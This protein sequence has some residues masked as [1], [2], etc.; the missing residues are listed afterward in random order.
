MGAGVSRREFGKTAG[1]AGL[2]ASGAVLLGA[3][4][5]DSVTASTAAAGKAWRVSGER[6]A[7]LGS[8][9]SKMKSF[10][11]ARGISCGQLA[12]ARKG[13]LVLARGYTWTN[14]DSL[15]TQPT[16]LFRIASLSK[17]VTGAAILRL[18]QEGKLS[19]DAPVTRLLSLTAPSGQTM[20]PRLKDVTVRRLLHHLGGWDSSA[21]FDPMFRDGPVASAQGVPLPVSKANIMKY[22]NG[23]K[24]DRAPGSKYAYSN[25]GYMLLGRIIEQVGGADYRTY[26]QKKVLGPSGIQRMRLGR[27]L[28]ANA[29]AGEVPYV[30]QYNASTVMDASGTKVPFPYGGFNLEN[31]DSHGGWL[32]SAV[33]LVRFAG[34]FDGANSVL[35]STSIGR[36]F[37]KPETGVESNG[38]WYGC[39]W[40]VRSVTK[41]RNTWH[42]GSLPGT[43][44]ILVRRYDGLTWA[45]LFNQRDDPSGKSY[46]DIDGLLHVAAD[47]VTTWPTGDLFGKYL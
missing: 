19:L 4:S 36:A 17:P 34:L 41:G 7:G 39:G 6:G 15:K 14:D 37:A 47:A 12:V 9:D 30:S 1:L 35:N 11:Q 32:S 31:M 8:F 44:T 10:M 2:G 24:L 27:S 28:K 43:H 3:C 40:S 25:Y 22:M 23:H 18:V 45:A 20:D 33:D 16:S 46:S 13:K 42:T 21:S 5:D 38:S 29:V 26:V